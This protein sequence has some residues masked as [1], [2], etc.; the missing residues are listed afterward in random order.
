MDSTLVHHVSTPLL[1]HGGD[2]VDLLAIEDAAQ[3]LAIEPSADVRLVATLATRFQTGM[4]L[5]RDQ[6]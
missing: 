6:Q 5:R 4:L 1:R 3:W 2:D